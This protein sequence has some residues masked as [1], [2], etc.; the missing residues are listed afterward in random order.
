MQSGSDSGRS[1]D[2]HD[3]AT[4]LRAFAPPQLCPIRQLFFVL[5]IEFA[6]FT[7]ELHHI[8]PHG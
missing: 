8:L 5:S 7:K 4:W 3:V 6:Q 1:G 2:A